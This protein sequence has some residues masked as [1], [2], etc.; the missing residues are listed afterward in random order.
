METWFVF[1]LFPLASL[2]LELFGQKVLLAFVLL[3]AFFL[4]CK[5]YIVK[6]VK[7]F[8]SSVG[9]LSI[10]CFCKLLFV[11]LCHQIKIFVFFI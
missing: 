6:V 3:A 4:E 8:S 9:T 1:S 10:F 11:K 7:M 2:V 5:I